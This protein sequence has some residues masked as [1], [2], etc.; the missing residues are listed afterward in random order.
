R[1]GHGAAIAGGPARPALDA[2]PTDRDA[3]RTMKGPPLDRGCGATGVA[4]PARGRARR[5]PSRLGC[6][7]RTWV[8]RTIGAAETG[9]MPAPRNINHDVPGRSRFPAKTGF[10]CPVDVGGLTAVR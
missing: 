7:C 1:A 10:F 5:R 9:H 4:G 8:G 3:C 2:N 6:A